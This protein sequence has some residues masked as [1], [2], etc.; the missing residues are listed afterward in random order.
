[1]RKIVRLA[2]AEL[3]PDDALDGRLGHRKRHEPRAHDCCTAARPTARR[4]ASP[5][6]APTDRRV[7]AGRTHRQ[8]QRQPQRA[9]G[10][11]LPVELRACRGSVPPGLYPMLISIISPVNPGPPESGRRRSAA[12][13]NPSAA[14]AYIP[15][16]A[17][18][19][20]PAPACRDPTNGPV[21]PIRATS[22]SR[23]CSESGRSRRALSRPAQIQ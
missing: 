8:P 6:A 17:D 11:Q 10:I 1:M 4:Q 3:V 14:A 18:R 12:A 20:T 23:S 9:P 5:S 19:T 16:R 22:R 7:I 21:R 13:E 15:P 2:V